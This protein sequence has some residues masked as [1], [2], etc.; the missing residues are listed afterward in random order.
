[1]LFNS[2]SFLIFFPVVTALYF[3]L[4]AQHARVLL[5]LGASCAFYM[6]FVPS[7]ILILGFTIVVDYVAGI[8]IARSTT[9]RGQFLLLSVVANVGMLAV[10]KYY[11]FLSEN[12]VLAGRLFGAHLS[13]PI[14]NIVLPIGLSFHTFQ[15]M[16]YTIEVYYGRQEPERNFL[17]Y[18]LY[19]MFY[20]QLVAGPIERPQNLL[21]QFRTWHQFDYGRVTSGLRRMAWG[22]FKKVVVADR[23][24]SFV[25]FVYD[26]PR[27][28]HGLMLISAT[29]VFAFQIYLDFSAYSDIALG[30][31]RVM[32]FEL[33]ENF[34]T[35]Y[36]SQTISEFWRR[37]HI[38]LSTW[39]RDYVYIP[40]GGSRAGRRRQYRNLLV[41]F[42]LSG[43][44]HGASWTFVI[45]GALHGTY[46]VAG[47]LT[48]SVRVR[49]WRLLPFREGDLFRR[50]L[51]T[52][53]TFLLVT[54]AWIF[55][56]ARTLETSTYVVQH[57]FTGLT[58]DLRALMAG[59]LATAVPV[60]GLLPRLALIALVV[61]V[62]GWG[63]AWNRLEARIA[64]AGTLWRYA[65][66]LTLI[67]GTIFGSGGAAA[68]Q[69]IYFQF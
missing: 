8:L 2:V 23:L 39:F 30:A 21:P 35:P 59:N 11:G 64:R 33:M 28:Y 40:L 31:A 1:M 45:W 68:Q 36:F 13:P 27:Q 69:F 43:L 55:F 42:L 5:L 58:G 16:S 60:P 65:V 32:G 6:A 61:A 14:L 46:L 17:V 10:F 49:L 51:A 34:R 63:G 62:E 54:F 41:V 66:Y 56:R 9:H 57:L 47:Q 18:A 24:A 26:N 53:T 3:A 29:V 37:W 48:A 67:Y 38:S 22:M 25:D 44:W 15:A 4:R 50:G 52:L 19:V 7:Y 20:P 12:V